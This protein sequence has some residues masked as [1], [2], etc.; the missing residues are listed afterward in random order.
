ME[1]FGVFVRM[2]GCLNFASLYT[3]ENFMVDSTLK[4]NDDNRAKFCV[5]KLIREWKCSFTT[6]NDAQKPA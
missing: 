1:V 4:G 3:E 5:E 2:D 6:P